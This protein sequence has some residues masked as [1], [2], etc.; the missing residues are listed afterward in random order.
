MARESGF[1]WLPQMQMDMEAGMKIDELLNL[2]IP[3][4]KWVVRD[5][6]PSAAVSILW[7]TPSIGKT[8]FSL[9]LS[10]RVAS[11]EPFLGMETVQ[12]AI[13][14]YYL[15][16]GKRSSRDRLE[17]HPLPKDR[18][19][20]LPIEFEYSLRLNLYDE[21]DWKTMGEKA[22]GHSLVI[23]DPLMALESK[24]LELNNNDKGRDFMRR[25][26]T[27]ANDSGCAFLIVHH[28][29]KVSHAEI[30]FPNEDTED[31]SML[32]AQA[33]LALASTRMYLR[34]NVNNKPY[35]KLLRIY[36]KE[37]ESRTMAL[38]RS[39]LWFERTAKQDKQP[40]FSE[41]LAIDLPVIP[42]AK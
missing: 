14:Y 13:L 39:G 34:T 18:M 30:Q 23:I 22:K 41:R 33:W 26:E 8:F 35:G 12:G 42:Q 4:I 16:G 29:R 21:L 6:L 31:A 15:E 32:G 3:P 40:S 25:L 5:F 36:G 11:G 7:G 38:K 9:D 24:G 2:D 28:R 10:V 37:V 1:H 19:Q 17:K 20:T 27:I